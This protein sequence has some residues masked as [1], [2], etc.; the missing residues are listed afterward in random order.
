MSVLGRTSAKG[1]QVKGEAGTLARDSARIRHN[2]AAGDREAGPISPLS[3]LA[4]DER[5]VSFVFFAVVLPVILLMGILSVD[6]GNWF[7]HKKRAQTLVDAAVFAGAS[8]FQGCFHDPTAA[9]TRIEQT[10]LEYA[11]DTNRYLATLNIQ[12]QEPQDL[13]I[14]LNSA[15]YWDGSYPPDN[16]LG[17]PCDTRFLD[18]RATDDKAPLLFG[19]LPVAASPHAQARVEIRSV[20]EESGLLPFAV[21]EIDPAAVF[22]IFIDD[23]NGAVVDW[24]QLD[25]NDSYDNDGD[26]TTPFPF[27]AW[28][29]SGGQEQVCISCNGT[30]HNTSVVILVSKED[31]SPSMGG[32][33]AQI[34]GQSPSLIR[35]YAGSGSG[36]GLSFIHGFQEAAAP[37]RLNPNIRDVNVIDTGCNP[38]SDF[39]APYFTLQGDCSAVVR[40]VIDFGPGAANPPT[41]YPTCARV[42]G[43]T[44]S[45][46]GPYGVWTGSVALNA[47]S[48]RQTVNI[49]WEVKDLNIGNGTCKNSNAASNTFSKAAA[50]YVADDA[51]GPVEYL[52]LFAKTNIP[53]CAGGTPVADANSVS[54]GK[55]YCYTV[56]VGL[57]LPLRLQPATADPLLLHF[58]S[59]SGS[60]NQALDCDHPNLTLRDEV[61]DG[62]KTTYA[63]NFD[64]WDNDPTTPMTWDDITCSQYGTN[65]LPPDDFVNDP[66]PNCVAAKT[67]DVQDMQKGLH[68][69]FETPCTP[70]YWPAKN[71]TQAQIDDFFINH[72]FTNDK[73]YITLVVTDITAFTGSGAEN[74]PVK[75]FAGFYATGWDVVGN[76]RPCLDNAP[77]PWYGENYRR[78]LDNGDVWGH[79]VNIVIFSSSGLPNDPL[80]NFDEVGTCIAVLV[81]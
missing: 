76:V 47:G 68:D 13:H 12:E 46:G 58:A 45:A 20:R 71:A 75:Y 14:V 77:H 19:F 26:S 60:L 27:S 3:R 40:A 30:S 36:S 33:L 7:V 22:A 44:W 2:G 17:T 32:T 24:Q 56:A 21:P 5:G 25:Q 66:T 49:P 16:T 57:Q 42:A 34:C 35:C 74:E 70:N 69:R 39:S 9:N 67:G 65:D 54:K 43:F 78:S 8:G 53:D 38:L 61:R 15:A 10:A 73:R 29:T 1:E 79:F 72:D 62:C 81:E 64:D 18:A 41:D 80:C 52:E 28:V 63:L 48:G 51:S 23:D 4:R 6:V 11:G 55:T 31:T 50:P 59:K 37:N